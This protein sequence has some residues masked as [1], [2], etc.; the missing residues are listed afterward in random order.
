[1]KRKCSDSQA[2]VTRPNP[3]ISSYANVWDFLL[4]GKCNEK[5]QQEL[6][7]ITEG[8]EGNWVE[9]QNF[10]LIHRIIL[11][12]STKSLAAELAECPNAVYFTDAQNRTALDWATARIQLE[13]MS[14]LLQAGA[15]PNNMDV[16]GRTPVLHAVDS[17]DVACL[18]LILEAGGDPNPVMPEGLFR[19]SPLTA[20]GYAGMPDMLR[21][22]LDFEANPNASNPEGQTALHAVARTKNVECALLL[23]QFGADMNA[24]PGNTGSPLKV[25]ITHNNHP[26]LQLFVDQCYE[27]ITTVRLKGRS[28]YV[29]VEQGLVALHENPV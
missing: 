28:P 6:G 10:P 2:A 9:E 4:R 29:F 19:S 1:M 3:M 11:G 7:C 26:V 14:L 21:V 23:L 15:D 22:L 16:S 17:H 20:A 13:D 24:S 5:E 25:A 18:R 12:F 27:Y 8:G